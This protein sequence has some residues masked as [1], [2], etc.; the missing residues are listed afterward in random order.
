VRSSSAPCPSHNYD[1]EQRKI[2][3]DRRQ[4]CSVL[5]CLIACSSK[6]GEQ[7]KRLALVFFGHRL[8]NYRL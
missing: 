1:T 5:A 4:Y 6:F 2:A 3:K 7:Q 8:R